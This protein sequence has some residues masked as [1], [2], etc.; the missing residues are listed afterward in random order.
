MPLGS[1]FDMHIFAGPSK[2]RYEQ[3]VVDSVTIVESGATFTATP[4]IVTRKDSTWGGHFGADVSYPVYESLSTSVR[5][6]AFLRYAKGSSDIQ[7][8][9]NR[10][11]TDMR[12]RPIRR[13][14]SLLVLSGR[15][16]RRVLGPARRS[17]RAM[18]GG[19]SIRG[20]R[21]RDERGGG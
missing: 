2:F 8:V 6:G 11:S 21:G 14:S 10:V 13:R 16:P 9:S 18:Y 17:A 1:K 5:L 3:D 12:R 19:M 15:A 7:V 20:Q 4:N